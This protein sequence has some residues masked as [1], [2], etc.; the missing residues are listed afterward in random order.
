MKR[1][2]LVLTGIV[3][4]LLL[5]AVTGIVLASNPPAINWWVIGGG[6]AGSSS[7]LSVMLNGTLGQPVVGS[8]AGGDVMLNSG[9]WYGSPPLA[10]FYVPVVKK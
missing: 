7:A 6:G 5:V 1:L 9:F 3:L 8:S 2:R 4:A 10:Y